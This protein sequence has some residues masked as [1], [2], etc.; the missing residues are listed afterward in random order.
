MVPAAAGG[1][2]VV[3]AAPRTRGD[4]PSACSTAGWRAPCSPHARGWS[5]L[6]QRQAP[7]RALLPARAGMVPAPAR[8]PGGGLP[9]PRTRGDGPPYGNGKHPSEL[10]SPH[11]RG[12]SRSGVRLGRYGDLLPARAGMVPDST[13]ARPGFWT[14]SPHAR[15]WSPLRTAR[16]RTASLLPA[17]AGMVPRSRGGAHRP[18]LPAPAGTS[19]SGHR[20]EASPPST[21]TPAPHKSRAN[22]APATPP[23]PNASPVQGPA[24]TAPHP[25]G[26]KAARAG[27]QLPW[28]T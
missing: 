3:L 27:P 17:R 15:G 5:P 18:L 28:P 12:W 24:H 9:A 11:A 4:G 21:A 25:V 2:G 6:R 16:L 8:L 7:E 10:C 20:K 1:A 26:A 23:R 22:V 19:T 14:C 13:A